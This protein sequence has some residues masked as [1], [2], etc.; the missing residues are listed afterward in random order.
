MNLRTGKLVTRRNAK[1]I[2]LPDTII[3]RVEELATKDG[4]KRVKFMNLRAGTRLVPLDWT[5]G[6]DYEEEEPSEGNPTK[7]WI[8]VTRK[9]VRNRIQTTLIRTPLKWTLQYRIPTV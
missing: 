4:I 3:D 1:T 5:A 2:P 9:M 6:V 8:P 7:K